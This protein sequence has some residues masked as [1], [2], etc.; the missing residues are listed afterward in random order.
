MG[1]ASFE[2]NA[3]VLIDKVPHTLKRKLDG[4]FWQ[5]EDERTGRIKEYRIP[6]LQKLYTKGSLIFAHDPLLSPR[7]T[8]YQ[9]K[10]QRMIVQMLEHS[11]DEWERTKIRREYVLSVKDLPSTEKVLVPEIRKVWERRG[12]TGP[13][14]HW[15]TVA[16]WKRIY[17]ASGNDVFLLNARN[18]RKGN[19]TR[20]SPKDLLKFVEDAVEDVYMTRERKTMT[21]VLDTAIV[22]VE[23]ENQLRTKQDHLRL[24]SLRMIRTAINAISAFDRHAARY[25]QMAAIRKF[26]SVLHM[27][28]AN[29]PLE[30]AELD[31]TKLDLF[32]IEDETGV[33]LGRPW[34]AVCIDANTR[35]VLGIYIGFEPPSYLTVAR[36]LKHAFLPKVDLHE[37]Y[38]DIKNDWDAHGVMDKL[39]LDN[40]LENHGNS[41]D[42]ACFSLGIEIQYT[43]RKTPWWK[44]K[45]E[46]FIGTL[47]RGIAHGNPGTTFANIFDKD[48]YNP[49]E[50][51]VITLSRL[52]EIAHRWIVDVYHQR[53]HRSLD[54]I[55]PAAKW[56]SGIAVED[57]KLPEDPARLDAIMGRVEHRVL[58]HEGIELEKFFYNSDELR[59]L[60]R[61]LGDKLDVA[62]RVDDGDLGHI[63][64]IAPDKSS[65]IRVPCLDLDYA[66]GLSLWQHRVIRR[67]NRE[68]RKRRDNANEWRH[69]K[70]ELGEL[71]QNEL[72]G[73]RKKTSASRTARY[74]DAQPP[75]DRIAAESPALKTAITSSAPVSPPQ[76]SPRPP[77]RPAGI[78]R[79]T[80]APIIQVRHGYRPEENIN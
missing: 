79:P 46:R 62:I 35:C 61:R 76:N 8:A 16:K 64:V 15:T 24:P 12:C 39:V 30:A 33:P 1:V 5:L 11:K 4:E 57:I 52:R 48:D 53:P 80:F 41:L 17:I 70:V 38:P 25:G 56:S 71:I 7:D 19:R 43:P 66:N 2:R 32:V 49:A 14:P 65:V 60:R 42:A 54:E 69:A 50:H 75:E 6:E 40:A 59:V 20:R 78:T 67:F 31:H 21:D 34:L 22:R 72:H 23:R 10:L 58:T 27:N 29:R 26:R 63:H 9:E 13:I 37:R 28:V 45:I 55:S 74:I 77:V 18:H 3:A 36:C 51:A 47:N 73:K 68:H 44:G